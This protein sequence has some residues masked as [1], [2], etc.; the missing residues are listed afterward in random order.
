MPG[1]NPQKSA[2]Q[3]RNG[4]TVSVLIGDTVIAFAQTVGHQLPMGA[5]QLYGI[6]SSKPQEVQQ[7]RMSPQISLDMFALTARGQKLLTD[8]QN[9]AYILAGNQFELYILDGQSNTTI[10]SYVGCKAQNFAESIP[11]NA[12]VR[13]T[14]TFL[15]MDVL[16]PAGNSIMDTG[17]NAMDIATLAAV[18]G[19]VATGG[20]NLGLNI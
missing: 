11:A 5:E 20:V 8:N 16:D 4:N 1:F 9:I 17:E 7:L 13:D 10:F 19:A 14:I 15:A 6:G 12:P 2:N 18:A 3:A